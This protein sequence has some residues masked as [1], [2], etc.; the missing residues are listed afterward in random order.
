MKLLGL[1]LIPPRLF[2]VLLVTVGAHQFNLVFRILLRSWA[3]E[4]YARIRHAAF[5]WWSRNF[6]R[7]CGIRVEMEGTP[8]TGPFLL[9]SNHVSYVDV[10]VLGQFID[11]VF[12]GK[13]DLRGWPILGWMFNTSDTIFIN[14]TRRRDLLRVM[15]KV[16]DY[17]QRGYGVVLFPEGTSSKGDTILPFKTSLLEYAATRGLPVHWVT[18]NYETPPG[19]PPAHHSVCWWGDEPLLPH[20]YRL[21]QLPRAKATV[22]FGTEPVRSTDRKELSET[23]RQTMFEAFRPMD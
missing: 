19:H 4:R 1:L 7:I 6:C 23:L 18:L 21:L 8:P 12:I 14:R 13:A 17:R 22:H 9:V 20:A 2:L 11:A 16:E 10:T 15:E 3:P 5:R